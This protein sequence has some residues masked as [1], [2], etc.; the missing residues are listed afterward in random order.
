MGAQ[1]GGHLK[2]RLSKLRVWRAGDRT[3]N[4]LYMDA[5]SASSAAAEATAGDGEGETLAR[6]APP[7]RPQAQSGQGD[8]ER[9][10]ASPPSCT[11]RVAP[12]AVQLGAAPT[13]AAAMGHGLGECCSEAALGLPPDAAMH[14]GAAAATA[15]AVAVGLRRGE[16]DG[17]DV[18]APDARRGCGLFPDWACKPPP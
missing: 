15:S 1:G 18:G 6:P 9:A 10:G 13:L 8:G 7:P 4:E 17:A 12:A 16:L 2:T 5:V 3:A 11:S 14:A